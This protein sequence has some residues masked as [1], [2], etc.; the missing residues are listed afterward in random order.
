[1]HKIMFKTF[2]NGDK[3]SIKQSKIKLKHVD[4]PII[5]DLK[6]AVI[7]MKKACRT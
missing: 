3:T 1:M 6:I 7:P 2:G 4:V 5:V